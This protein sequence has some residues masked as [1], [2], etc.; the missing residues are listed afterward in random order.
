MG[1][2]IAEQSTNPEDEWVY[3]TILSYGEY[4]EVLE[5]EHI[6]EIIKNKILK[7]VKKYL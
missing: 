6:R 1:E 2:Q 4:A 3:G 5:P 7:T